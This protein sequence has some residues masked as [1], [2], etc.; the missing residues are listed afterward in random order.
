MFRPVINY[1]FMYYQLFLEKRN[2]SG[3]RCRENNTTNC[4]FNNYFSNIVP[5]IRW[6]GKI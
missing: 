4:E 6:C 1:G 5:F 2:V 3:K